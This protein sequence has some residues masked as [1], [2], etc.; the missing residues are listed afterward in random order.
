M[1]P[2]RTVIRV[3]WRDGA[4]CARLGPEEVCFA[5]QPAAV[6]WAVREARALWFDCGK[7]AQVVLHGKH[8]RIRWERT[9]GR[10]PR[11]TPG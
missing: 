8:G 2:K 4:W 1:K 9:Y 11:R 5:T 6:K 7:L 10:D 3:R